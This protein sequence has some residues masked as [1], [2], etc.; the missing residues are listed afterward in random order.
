M[1]TLVC[2]IELNKNTGITITVENPDGKIT[3]T[4]VLNGESIT[5]KSAGETDTSTI[6][7]TPDSITIKCKT[8]KLETE[9]TTCTSTMATKV[10]AKTD[11]TVN[12]DKNIALT[13][14]SNLEGT[15]SQLVLKGNAKA[16]I[17]APIVK[18]AATGP[19]NVEGQVTTIKGS[20]TNIQGSLVKIG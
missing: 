19:M 18:V 9:T 14:T 17:S 16:D 13:A 6:T 12:A 11:V 20:V 4:A 1:G 3:Q 7:Q 2:R 8:F 15:G 10:S 5:I